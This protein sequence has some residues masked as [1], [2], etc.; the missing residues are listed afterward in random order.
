M[1]PRQVIDGAQDD[2]RPDKMLVFECL[3]FGMVKAVVREFVG[4]TGFNFR[5]EDPGQQ[6]CV[7]R[8]S[9]LCGHRH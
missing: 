6:M 3:R 2:Q 4:A 5:D 9:V 1:R 7:F 8:L